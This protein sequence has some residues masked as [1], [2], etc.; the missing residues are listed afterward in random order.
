MFLTSFPVK[1]RL[2]AG[3]FPANKNLFA[4]TVAENMNVFART[5]LENKVLFQYFVSIPEM[6][7]PVAKAKMSQLASRRYMVVMYRGVGIQ[8][9]LNSV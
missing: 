3:T 6:D 5:P 7:T 9:I 4:G 2:F 1:K 8:D